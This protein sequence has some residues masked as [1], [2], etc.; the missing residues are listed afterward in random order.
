MEKTPFIERLD[1]LIGNEKPFSWAAKVGIPP[2]TFSRI[3]NE[4]GQAKSDAL[5]RISEITG[6]SIDWLLTGEG[7][8]RRGTYPEEGTIGDGDLAKY[9]AGDLGD[10][11]VIPRYNVEASA[12]GG[13]MIHTEQIVDYLAFKTEWL[14][15]EVGITPANAVVIS[16]TGDSMEPNL[17][18]GDLILVDTGIQRFENDA[19]YVLQTGGS[20]LVKRVQVKLDG[21]VIVKSDNNRYDPEIFRGEEAERLIVVGRMVRRVVR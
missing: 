6:C 5:M 8:M 19:I 13:A 12:G 3:Y 15:R 1:N 16:V 20:L 9:T 4:G 2:A 18:E 11:Y 17:C 7:P 10:D 21:T 14:R